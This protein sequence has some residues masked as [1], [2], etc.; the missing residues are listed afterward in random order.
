[1]QGINLNALTEK[2]KKNYQLLNIMFVLLSACN[3]NCIHCYIPEHTCKGLST[4]K[5]KETILEA[6]H[7]GALNVT[8]TGGEIFVRDDIYE[9]IKFARDQYLRV[10]LMSNAYALNEH[11]INL[12]SKLGIA[13]FSTTLF[14]MDSRIHERITNVSGSFERV[15][16]N[17]LLLK[18]A[19]IPIT[20]KTPLMEINKYAYREVEKFA[21]D[22]GFNFM[23]TTTIF[24][25]TDGND[26]PHELQINHNLTQIICETE[27]IL[28]KYRPRNITTEKSGIPCSAGFCNICV[29]YDG[30]VWPCNS[31][32][33]NLGNIKNSPLSH[34]WNN[35][36]E[37]WQWRRES[38]K[39]IETCSICNLKSHCLRCPGMALL[40]DNDLYGC[41][42]SAK[43]IAQE[44]IKGG[45]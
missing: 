16:R 40:E 37:L 20:I 31:L 42:K 29:N 36:E 23:T 10:F 2:C 21:E 38:I 11:D 44:K 6:R 5:I 30:A 35:S 8:F 12:L 7:L 41:S 15:Y 32:L 24:S 18:E 33:L 14:S 34:I 45:I 9:L 43:I 27:K 13:E 17:V 22:N 19:N 28:T 39:P 26:S 3:H 4:E 1:M 25:K